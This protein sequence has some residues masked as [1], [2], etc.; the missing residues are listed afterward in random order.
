MISKIG[1]KNRAF[2]N[3]FLLAILK[4][5]VKK[6]KNYIFILNS[7]EI[8]KLEKTQ[9]FFQFYRFPYSKIKIPE[10]L[11]AKCKL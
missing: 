10:K 1:Y 3:I 2:S 7:P 8:E 5:I 6:K 11:R 9:L 4:T